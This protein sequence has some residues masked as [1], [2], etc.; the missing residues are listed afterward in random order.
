MGEGGSGKR[1]EDGKGK[2]LTGFLPLE[3]AGQFHF[4]HSGGAEKGGDKGL[5]TWKRKKEITS[6]RRGAVCD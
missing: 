3:K 4:L 6:S 1:K 2:G 5:P